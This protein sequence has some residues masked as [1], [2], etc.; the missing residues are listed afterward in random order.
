MFHFASAESLHLLPPGGVAAN[1][2][3]EMK[4]KAIMQYINISAIFSPFI[5]FSFY[6][7]SFVNQITHCLIISFFSCRGNLICVPAGIME[8]L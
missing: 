2:Q 6:I 8:F 4:V 1:M 7:L 3:T 5:L